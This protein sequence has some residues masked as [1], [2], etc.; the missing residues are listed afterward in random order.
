MKNLRYTRAYDELPDSAHGAE[1][2]TLDPAP[3]L[4]EGDH[5]HLDGQRQHQRGGRRDKTGAELGGLAPS[6]YSFMGAQRDLVDHAA[7]RR[8]GVVGG[9]G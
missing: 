8:A 2:T 6:N 4:G 7:D 3:L 9:C 1:D 5:R